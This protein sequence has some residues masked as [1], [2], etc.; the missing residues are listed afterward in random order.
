MMALFYL[1]F[2][3]NSFQNFL[4]QIAGSYLSSAFKTEITIGHINYDGWTYFSIDDVYWGD[5]KKDTLFY[6][7]NM[8][9]DIGGIEIDSSRF[10]LSKLNVDGAVC[11]IVTYPDGTFNIN[12]LFNII[13]PNDTLPKDPNA[14][15]FK[16][17]FDEV[18]LTNSQFRLID[19]THQ[20]ESEG[21]D[22]FNEN[23]YNINLKALHFKIIEDSLHFNLQNLSAIEQSGFELKSMK[24]KAIVCS[25]L[26]QFDGLE[27]VTGN[28]LIKNFVSM[29]FENWDSCANDFMSNV[30]LK[31]DLKQSKISMNDIAFFAPAL[32]I[33]NY[34]VITDAKIRGTI[35]NLKIR[36]ANIKYANNTSFSGNISMN[37]LPNIDQTFIEA[38]ADFAATDKSELEK[39]I[40]MPLPDELNK[41]GVLKFKGH[42]TGF[43]N[44]FVSY[45]KFETPFGNISTDLNIKLAKDARQSVYS[46]ILNINNFNLG[47]YLENK[48]F[49]FTT[50]NATINGKGLDFKTLKAKVKSNL[51]YFDFNGYRY[52]NLSL[53]ALCDKKNLNGDFEIKDE[54]IKI[55]LLGNVDLSKDIPEFNFNSIIDGA[56]L[57]ALNFSK[58][59]IYL[60]TKI[61]GD[62]AIKTI[63]KNSGTIN[64]R[65]TIF[66][67][68]GSD[69]TIN[70]IKL[71]S[72]NTN[73]RILN[74][75][76]DFADGN[77]QG[78]YNFADLHKC[79]YNLLC[80]VAP[81]YLKPYHEKEISKQDFD[82]ELSVR[83]TDNLSPMFF[84]EIDVNDLNV[85]GSFS[86]VNNTAEIIGFTETFRYNNFYFSDLILK[87]KLIEGKKAEL[88]FGI[89][90]FSK[91]DTLMIHEFAVKSTIENNRADLHL[92]V[93]DT[94]SLIYSNINAKLLFELENIKLLFDESNFV[95]NS[96][97]WNINKTG[98]V[99]FGNRNLSFSNFSINN[100]DQQIF[101]T[102]FY[103]FK[104]KERNVLIA[105]N[106][107]NLSNINIF[108]PRINIKFAGLTNGNVVLRTM[109]GKNLFTNNLWVTQFALDN[110]TVGDFEIN[111]RLDSKFDRLT[112][113]AKSL[114]G[115]LNNFNAVGYWILES[116]E[117]NADI[118]FE[119]AEIK[120]LQAFAK[121]YITLYD[122][123]ASLNAKLTGTLAKP[124]VNGSLM[125]NNIVT[126]IEYLKTIYNLSGKFNFNKN[127]IAFEPFKIYDSKKHTADVSGKIA[128]KNFSD[129]SFD[130]LINNFNEFQILNTTAKDNYLFYGTAYGSGD[131][132]IK[133]PIDDIELNIKAT[134][135]KNT[136]IYIAPF[137]S[138]E[139]SVEE[140][141]HFVDKDTLNKS[142]IN[143]NPSLSGFS[144]NMLVNATTDAEVQIVFDE[145]TDDKISAIGDGTIKLELNKQGVFNMFGEY[146]VLEGDYVFSALNVVNKKFKL[147]KSTIEWNGDP[148]DAKLNINGVYKHR[149][150][151]NELLNTSATSNSNDQSGQSNQRMLVECLLNIN[152]SLQSPQYNFDL[153]FP[154]IDNSMNGSNL[155]DLNVALNNLR[156]EPQQMTQQIINLM[157]FGKFARIS[158]SNT[159]TT[160]A[161]TALGI[162]TLSELASTQL[163]NMLN[164][165]IP[166]MNITIDV[167]NAVDPLK[168]R[169]FLFTAS[170]RVLDNRLELQGSYATDNSQNNFLAQYNIS[171][172]GNFKARAFNRQLVDPIF[173]RNVST[174]GFSLFYRKEF[175]NLL[176]LF[177]P[178]NLLY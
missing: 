1:I 107:F 138:S 102:G 24:A 25:K 147:Q 20:F 63:D 150:T 52:T 177:K 36:D 122:G 140:L 62:F 65:N 109:D 81:A 72:S 124:V 33:F 60:S 163:T 90:R 125:A 27:A 7:K 146:N 80:K 157:V 95:F 5:Q 162:N 77:I 66:D 38:N 168:G 101:L 53:T 144:L 39:I 111:G 23:F 73:K 121:E 156:K 159:A 145:N 11:N 91:S 17:I 30:Y 19:S 152:G 176:D 161:G 15:R 41:F 88:L 135:S 173:S 29:S 18:N 34:S 170:K 28:S 51:S 8:Q 129:F 42:Y 120:S 142:V 67:F 139:S 50:L 169:N 148:L 136:K 48:N 166:N 10:V 115:K 119:N 103:N 56:S 134:A 126:R 26:M 37:G 64:F 127:E 16:L 14:P 70:H 151:I 100:N 76:S 92:I 74:F 82:F 68:N 171:K 83:N 4:I 158:N 165:V 12:T 143:R 75:S 114:K 154:E 174:Q 21:F 153:N 3:N 97:K 59:E 105:L 112:F 43:I 164:K 141:I 35:R 132:T 149:T 167:L 117:I 6:L 98:I 47:A 106:D 31:G 79:F 94:S 118:G 96:S 54:N 137:G 116:G 123:K 85:K 175:D 69:F 128:H 71:F 178:K 9:F 49:R 87:T 22:P 2:N 104:N 108:L 61:N 160:N 172:N 86:N 57:K 46:G 89:S 45:G 99:D 155:S 78:Q 130:V 44:D 113:D 110:D 133:G 131:V 32:K 55:K 40:S 58:N 84:P 93:Q 13:D